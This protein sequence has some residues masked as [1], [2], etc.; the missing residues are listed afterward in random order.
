MEIDSKT[1]FNMNAKKCNDDDY[2]TVDIKQLIHFF[3]VDA[4]AQQDSSSIKGVIGEEFAFAC[5]KQYFEGIGKLATLITDN[6]KRTPCTTG[7]RKGYQLDG[8]LQVGEKLYQVEIKSWS[9]HGIGSKNRKMPIGGSCDDALVEQKKIFNHY[10]DSKEKEF[11]QSGVKKVLLE[12]NIP[13][14]IQELN[15]KPQPL[16]CL[17]EAVS[18]KDTKSSSP[19]FSVDVD[20][21]KIGNLK[22]CKSGEFTQV[23]IFSVSNYLR[24]I[25]ADA[26]KT[27][28]NPTIRLHLPRISAR[29]RRLQQIFQS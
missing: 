6:G 19:F 7:E 23:S 25:L 26:D 10:Y 8:W 15:L 29:I 22:E 16:L 4:G 27:G 12:M 13:K 9:F 14:K 3:D 24:G 1:A 21:D 20:K 17:W 28:P 18:P 5:M 11:L 2:L